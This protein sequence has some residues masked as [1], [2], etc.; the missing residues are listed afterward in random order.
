V[1]GRGEG[2]LG[3]RRRGNGGANVVHQTTIGAAFAHPT[4]QCPALSRA[5]SSGEGYE[6][7]GRPNFCC[8]FL[9]APRVATPTLPSAGPT[10]KP[11]RVSSRWISATSSAVTAG[12]GPVERVIAGARAIRVA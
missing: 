5:R 12:T 10:S 9:I 2:G 6:S 3:G 7:A 8:V 4:A 1:G 11:A